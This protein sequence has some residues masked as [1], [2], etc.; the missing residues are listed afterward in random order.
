[1]KKSRLAG[2]F[3]RTT[4]LTGVAAAMAAPAFAQ[5][6]GDDDTIIVTGSRLNQANLT[7]SSPVFQV[8]AGEIDTR[9]TSRIE[10]L[11]NILPQAFA[12]QTSEVANGA[13][14]TSSVDLRN[15]GSIRTLVLLDGRRL[16]FGSAQTSSPNLDM[17]PSQLVERV[18]VVTGG[19]SAVY[20]SDAMA[21][22][23]NFI[24]QRD[25]EGI[26]FDGQVGFYQ[27]GN[28]NEFANQLLIAS[29]IPTTGAVSDGRDVMASI[30]FGANTPDGRGNVTAYL[31]YQDQN[32]IRLGAR[33]YGV[34][35][36][37]TSRPAPN[38]INNVGCVGSSTFRRFFHPGGDVH[39]DPDGTL[40]PFVGGPS[41]TFNFSPDNF[42]QR[43]N[44]RFNFTA[45][46]R[47][48]LTDNIEAYLDTTFVNNTT[49][50]QI[51]FSG[52]FFRPF[53]VNCDNPLL[54]SGGGSHFDLLGCAA[55]PTADVPLTFGRRNVE[56]DPRNSFIETNS[57]RMVGGLRGDLSNGFAW[58]AYAQFAR[59]R[60][61]RISEGDI[62]FQKAQEALFTT[63]G[64]T[65]RSSLSATCVPW[66]VFERNADGTSRVTQAQT[67][68]IQ[69][70]GI[71][72]G[73]TQQIL[74]GGTM[75]GDLG[76]YGFQ[77]PWADSGV[78]A[79]LGVE[80]RKDLLDRVP[81]E[82]S[83]IPGGRGLTGTGGATLPI[84]GE[85]RVTELFMET[86]IPLITGRPYIEEFGINGAYRFSDYTTD[87]NNIENSFNT[88]TFAAGVTWQPTADIRLR[89]QFQ[90]AIRAPNVIELFTGQNTGLF[91]A[92]P[93]ANGLFD[94][95]AS[96]PGVP[97]AATATQCAFTGV[98]GAQ[99]GSIP[100]NPA[101][102]LNLVT[103][104][105]PLLTP[106]VSD[107]YTAGVVL[108]PSFAML[109]GL[110]L[111]VDYYDITVN[112]TIATIPAQQIL[113][114]CIAS[115]DPQFCG[116]IQRDRF[117]SL[118]LD[119]SNFEGIQVVNTNIASLAVRGLDVNAN[120]SMDTPFL[121]DDWG[122]WNFNYVGSFMFE[123]SFE[124]FPGSGV[125]ECKGLYAGQC[126]STP[127]NQYRHRLLT[128]W[129]TPWN[130]DLTFTHRF[131]SGV[132]LEG[133]PS[134]NGL[135]DHLDSANYLDLAAQWYVREGIALRGGVQ[136][137][138]G[139][140]PELTQSCGPAACNGN[141]IPG[142]YDAAGRFFFVGVTLSN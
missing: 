111:A 132:D 15:L 84:S 82:L 66:N 59:T 39:Q 133:G 108:T 14:G 32:E 50:A 97:P 112:N 79:L 131:M 102:Q 69:G 68:F 48:E 113:D 26:Q 72:N 88:S 67:D 94:P 109:D 63:D 138:M 55:T 19:A 77:F 83:R 56:G 34:C 101:G 130:V 5:D 61:L 35:A 103:G 98:T 46:S 124:S 75:S 92:S 119:N 7:S 104:G 11:V 17:I 6:D 80:Y 3:L 27:D 16:P 114:S 45:M 90:R 44:E 28:N 57:W 42:I 71:I 4:M 37:A 51:A 74:I 135:D 120:Y 22:V 12:A 128:T 95:C 62:N 20:G 73:T 30:L 70:T 100:D 106:E 125:V 110:T 87:G 107:S 47:Y 117:G 2:R 54:G 58:D 81:D 129:Q 65:C 10:D 89:G 52:S 31:S 85:V 53:Q 93:R 91:S 1:M 49:D 41:Q 36:Y 8:D 142:T 78:A 136:N 127:N 43:P 86:Q 123:N 140:D 60:L 23:V 134:G 139:R 21:G 29:Q 137:V 64:V 96:A 126:A 9:G 116:L 118:F 18:D 121:G 122:S 105:N 99:Y 33:D 76:Q 13:T 24:L 115:G 40:V 141:T 38:T 25:F